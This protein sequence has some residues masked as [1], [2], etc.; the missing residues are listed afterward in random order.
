MAVTRSEALVERLCTR[1]FLSLWS[2]ANPVARPG[3]ELCDLL[4][5][6]QPDLVIFSVKEVTL[7]PSENGDVEE[8]TYRRWH[9]KAVEESAKQL[10]GAERALSRAAQVIRR[11]GS[12]G[13][14]LP[15]AGARRVH[16]VAVALGGRGL[17]PIE[18]GDFGKGFV[19]VFDETSLDRILGELDTVTDF[20]DYLRVKEHL[21]GAGTA[22]VMAREEDLLAVYLHHGREVPTQA[23]VVLVQPGAWEELTG[24]PEW[25]ARK[26]TDEISYEWDRLIETF[27]SALTAGRLEWPVALTDGEQAL[28]VMARESRFARRVLAEAFVEFLMLA[29]AGKVRSRLVPSPSGILYVFLGRDAGQ[30]HEGREERASELQLRCLAARAHMARRGHRGTTVVGI[31]T[32]QDTSRGYSLEAAY[33]DIRDWTPEYEQRVTEMQRELGYFTKPLMTRGRADEYPPDAPAGE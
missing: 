30:S 8:A 10:Y 20:V 28:R 16:R 23:D 25:R 32:E 21:I 5:V 22:P 26:V 11:D 33:V 7:D 29:R 2:Y 12:P 19:H 6:C 9:R 13:L 18:Y 1:T 3:K 17:V 31:A 4:V 14:P 15:P 27:A 24:K